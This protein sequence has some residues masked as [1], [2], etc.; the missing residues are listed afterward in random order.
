MLKHVFVEFKKFFF[1]GEPPPAGESSRKLE[2]CE[3]N[4]GL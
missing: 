4:R 1:Q 2:K 3:S